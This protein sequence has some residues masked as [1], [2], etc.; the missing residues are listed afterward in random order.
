MT[1]GKNWNG[2]RCGSYY[3][4][5]ERRIMQ[6]IVKN[7]LT[8][9]EYKTYKDYLAN[10]KNL[11]PGCIKGDAGAKIELQKLLH[12]EGIIRIIEKVRRARQQGSKTNQGQY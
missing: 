12:Q 2:R 5:E 8:T 1:T 4:S 11:L 3:T 9:D 10:V 7:S 6:D